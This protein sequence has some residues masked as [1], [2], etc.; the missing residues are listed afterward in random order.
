MASRK[1]RD[2]DQGYQA[3]VRRFYA[4]ED[5]PVIDVG[6]LEAEGAKV[7]E[8]G[9]EGDGTRPVTVLDVATWN[10][11]GTGQIPERS[12]IRAWFDE[13]LP[14]A[15]ELVRRLLESVAAGK[16]D[17]AT[18]PEVLG[19]TFVAQI[20]KRMAAGIPPANAPETIARKGSST[21]LIDTGQLRSSITFRAR[22]RGYRP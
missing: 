21:P 20:Q 5:T 4:L 1:V 17:L 22:P 7:H 15:R 10:E 8:G 9:P 13:N 3:L 12:F 2:V 19:T 16:R 18:V 6:V 14:G 11:F